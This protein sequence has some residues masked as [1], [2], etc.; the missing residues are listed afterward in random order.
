[1]FLDEHRVSL[2]LVRHL[3]LVEMLLLLLLLRGGRRVDALGPVRVGLRGGGA[4]RRVRA[5]GQKVLTLTLG[6][7]LAST[8]LTLAAVTQLR[9]TPVRR[10]GVHELLLL[11]SVV[12]LTLNLTLHHL[13]LLSGVG[14]VKLLVALVDRPAHR[15]HVRRRGR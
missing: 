10:G 6:R 1:M 15:R 14:K 3:L 13:L 4:P 7:L 11:L 9:L 2:L 8:H 5:R 12:T